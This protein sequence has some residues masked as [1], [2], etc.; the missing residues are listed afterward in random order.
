MNYS[1]MC[2]CVTFLVIYILR[3]VLSPEDGSSLLPKPI[4]LFRVFYKTGE[5]F[6]YSLLILFA[7]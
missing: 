3:L 5:R 7:L 4:V 2:M 1:N 6:L